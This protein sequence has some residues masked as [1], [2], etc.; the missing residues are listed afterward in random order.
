MQP[1]DSNPG[2]LQPRDSNAGYYRM[3]TDTEL[4][5][6][7]SSVDLGNMMAEDDLEAEAPF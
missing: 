1:R 3:Q 4:N 7:G 6:L 5:R 2:F